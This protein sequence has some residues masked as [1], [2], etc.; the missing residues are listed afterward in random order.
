MLD[1]DATGG[2]VANA[3]GHALPGQVQGDRGAVQLEGVRGGVPVSGQVQDEPRKEVPSV[4]EWKAMH[5]YLCYE[6]QR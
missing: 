2:G 5:N 4:V 3:G 6:C 1:I